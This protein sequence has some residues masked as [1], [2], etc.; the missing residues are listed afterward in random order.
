MPKSKHRKRKKQAGPEAPFV[1]LQRQSTT[2]SVQNV[3]QAVAELS[4]RE[5]EKFPERVQEI[6]RLLREQYPPY[7]LSIVSSY[8]LMATVTPGKV[9]ANFD[10]GVFN[11]HHAEML[12]AMM[13]RIERATWSSQPPTPDK[14]D[15][16]FKALGEASRSFFQMRFLQDVDIPDEDLLLQSIQEKLRMNTQIVRNWG[17]FSQ[18]IAHSRE[19]YSIL[20]RCGRS[21]LG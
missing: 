17:H 12:Q 10:D 7:L 21:K 1:M 20:D 18:V 3:R 13:L 6:D 16:T 11:Q 14:V 19:L 2:E 5:T 15:E 8:G 4:K 9:Q